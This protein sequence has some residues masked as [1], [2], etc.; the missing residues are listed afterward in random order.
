MFHWSTVDS[1]VKQ[2]RIIREVCHGPTPDPLDW[3]HLLFSPVTFYGCYTLWIVI[4]TNTVIFQIDCPRIYFS[5]EPNVYTYIH[6]VKNI[7][8]D[9]HLNMIVQ[10]CH[11][12]HVFEHPL[13]RWP[14]DT[15]SLECALS[16]L[17]LLFSTFFE[18]SSV[19]HFLVTP[20]S[21]KSSI[22]AM[23]LV[24]LSL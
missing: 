4:H 22:C 8:N 5:T 23:Y 15:Y 10:R 7:Q 17:M 6:K 24:P 12:Q 16:L 19:T 18:I 2:R 20:Y 3:W 14:R 1:R 13:L 9:H 21:C 11:P